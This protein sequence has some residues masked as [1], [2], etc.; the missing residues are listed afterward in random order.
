MYYFGTDLSSHGHYY[1]DITDGR[2]ILQPFL[3]PT[4]VPFDPEKLTQNLTKGEWTIFQCAAHNKHCTAIAI[5]GSCVDQRPG[6]KSV[7][8]L[9][10]FLSLDQFL[11]RLRA[12]SLAMKIINQMPFEVDFEL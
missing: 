3:K 8:W 2:F 5:S 9:N 11:Q 6:T 10:E 7:F 1:F 4:D 12:N